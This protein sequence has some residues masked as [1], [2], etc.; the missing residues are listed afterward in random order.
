[1][2]RE[3]WFL[4]RTPNVLG[5]LRDQLA[6]TIEGI[7][8]CAAWAGGDADAA[9]AVRDAEQRG[10][11]AKRTLL[12]ELRAA[13]V[14]PLEPEDVFALSRGID[15]ILNYAGDL[16]SES[17]VMVC[18][19][20]AVIAGMVRLL[21]EAVRHIDDALGQ[22]ATDREAATRA[23]DEAIES[24]RAL[25]RAYYDG[26]AALLQ[27]PDRSERITRR[28]LYRRCARIG[29]VT[30]DVAERVVYAVVKEL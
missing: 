14:T 7:D 11:V 4:P 16:I 10:D 19:P 3:H 23:A 24:E 30:I 5:L 21:G 6:V 25:E 27:V 26:M 18:A 29:E 1:V 9:A 20:D 12:G 2:T 15:W 22:L 28:E 13:F 17:E 8:A